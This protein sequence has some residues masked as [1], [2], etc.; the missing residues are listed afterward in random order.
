MP[1]ALS[2]GIS[3]NQILP[4]FLQINPIGGELLHVLRAIMGLYLAII[5]LWLLGA[6]RGGDCQE[7]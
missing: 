1:I 5:V 2:Y 4:K 6:I 3:P 7:R